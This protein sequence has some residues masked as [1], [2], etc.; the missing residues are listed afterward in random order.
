M[1]WDEEPEEIC[2]NCR[3][4]KSF[5][6]QMQ[7]LYST[8]C[9]SL[10]CQSCA[11][12]IFNKQKFYECSECK[13]P[14]E[15]KN[16]VIDNIDR[17]RVN[18]EVRVRTR[19][20]KFFN[21]RREDFKTPEEYDDYLELEQDIV[22]DLTYGD[23]ACRVAADKR[24]KEYIAKNTALIERNRTR[25]AS[26]QKTAQDGSMD[27]DTGD[28]EGFAMQLMMPMQMPIQ[29][30]AVPVARPQEPKPEIDISSLPPQQQAEYHYKLQL[31]AAFKKEEAKKGGGFIPKFIALRC[32]S[33]AFGS[34]W[35]F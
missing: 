35:S 15:K 33:E 7:I 14:L 23:Q 10:L 19:L 9:G 20:T 2:P 29:A 27:I 3:T 31:E 18:E 26:E 6:G 17:Q 28:N 24:L 22:Y 12:L 21:C 1:E 8:C 34:L 5:A 32:Q 30:V 4:S 25:Q 13:Q 11:H 16:F